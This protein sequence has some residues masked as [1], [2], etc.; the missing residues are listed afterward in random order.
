MNESNV[1]NDRPLNQLLRMAVMA[2]VDSAVQI[3]IDRGDDIN[4]RDARGMTPL[5]LSAA[6][7][8]P[9]ICKL[10]LSAGADHSL[11]D[12]SGKTAV[13]IAI[14][15]GSLATSEIL[16]AVNAPVLAFPPSGIALDPM[17]AP[18]RALEAH[19]PVDTVADAAVLGEPGAS[20]APIEPEPPPSEPP[21]QEPDPPSAAVVDEIDDGEFDLSGWETE[22][23]S[24]RPEADL[25]I[26]DSASA[27]QIAITAHEPIDSSSE[28][29]DIDVYLPEVALPLA[30]ADD[31]EGRA[32][33]RRLLLRAIQARLHRPLPPLHH[34]G[35]RRVVRPHRRRL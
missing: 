21:M 35:T 22:E 31:A 23:E 9:A 33:L 32:T 3:H 34:R 8:K 27:V 19:P 14:A 18:K 11:L 15:A 20:T 28:W 24:T 25:V 30:R 12:P 2:G 5:M 6:R 29:D 26:V 4:A 7:N 13:Q 17:P 10:L 1:P 16:N